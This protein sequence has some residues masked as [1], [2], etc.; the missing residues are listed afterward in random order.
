MCPARDSTKRQTRRTVI[1]LQHD[2]ILT[3]Y[4]KGYAMD[5]IITWGTFILVLIVG[6]G[7]VAS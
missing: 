2:V 3:I 7:F 4:P 5:R 1:T 6:L